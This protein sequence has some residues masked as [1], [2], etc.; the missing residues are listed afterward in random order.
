MSGL[1]GD[2]IEKMLNEERKKQ[3]GMPQDDRDA[4]VLRFP[5]N[6][7]RDRDNHLLYQRV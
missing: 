7:Q 1:V 6:P 5:I 3:A 2:I 4:G